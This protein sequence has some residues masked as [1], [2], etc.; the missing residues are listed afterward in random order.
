MDRVGLALVRRLPHFD[1]DQILIQMNL[2]K[3]ST[4]VLALFVAMLFSF[5]VAENEQLRAAN[6]NADTGKC[7]VFIGT[8]TGPKSKGIYA[9]RMDESTGTLTPIG[10]V[11]ESPNPTFIALDAA[12]QRLYAANEIEHFE[13]KP[14]GAVT[15]FSIEAATGKLTQL[16]QESSAGGGPC[17]LV[18]DETGKNILVANYGGGSVAVLP[19]GADG[20][21]AQA[22]AFIQHSGKSVNPERQEKPHAHCMALDAANRFA[23]VCDLGIDKVMIYRFDPAQ[24]ALTSND[25]A[26]FSAQPGAGPRHMAFHPNGR[27]A[28][29]INELQSSITALAYDAKGG[30]LRELETV[31]LLPEDFKAPNISAE[32]AVHPS[33]KFLYGSNRGHN[34]ITVFQI[35]ARSR[36]LKF[37]E[38]QSTQG[39]TPRH[40]GIDPSGN[41]L[42]CANQDSN[43]VVVFKIDPK[44]GALIPTGQTLEFPSPVCVVFLP[45][46]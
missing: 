23:F 7:L 43:N 22:S 35:D 30:A 18:L 8:Y 34:S 17:H 38:R 39:K 16:N 25:P 14:A 33:G 29:V 12:H 42:L 44:T 15:G 26:S 41:F 9:A 3:I 11:G 1:A 24:G 5:V 27:F 28:Y 45:V 46:K 32:I 2:T 10:L 36:K 20:R 40:F 6:A 4:I 37:V 19:V 21:L 13:G 31:P